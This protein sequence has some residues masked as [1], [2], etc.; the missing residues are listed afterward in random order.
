MYLKR[1]EINGFKSFANKTEIILDS[2]ITGVVGPNG[3]GKSNISDAIRWVLGEQSSK[4]LRGSKMEDVIFNGTATRSRK[5]YA[6]VSLVFDNS[7]GK[8][9][10]DYSEI[11]I[12]RKMYRSGESEYYIN[13]EQVRLR[14]IVDLMRDTGIGKE[15]YSI[16]GQGKIDEILENRP[17]ARRRVIEEAA[18]I[19]KFRARKEEAEHKLEKTQDNISRISDI[20]S[21]LDSQLGPLME[22]SEKA[23]EYRRLFERQRIV[24]ANLFLLN[25]DRF[26][27][28]LEK[29][30][31]ELC[32]IEKEITELKAV[33]GVSAEEDARMSERLNE[34]T[35]QKDELTAKLTELTKESEKQAGIVALL[36]ERKAGIIS[37]I[38]RAKADREEKIRACEKHKELLAELDTRREKAESEITITDSSIE[39]VMGSIAELESGLEDKRASFF[40]EKGRIEII[41]SDITE[42]RTEISA[43]S[44][45]LE[46]A[47]KQQRD[48]LAR[49]DELQKD[50]ALRNMQVIEEKRMLNRAKDEISNT[51]AELNEKRFT[52][53]KLKTERSSLEEQYEASKNTLARANSEKQLLLDMKAEYDGYSESVKNLMRSAKSDLR[54]KKLIRG[55]FAELIRVPEKYETAIEVVLG[56][57]LQNVVVETEQDAKEIIDFLH[58]RKLGRVTFMPLD[59]LKVNRL[60]KEERSAITDRGFLAVASEVLEF[61]ESIRPAVEFALARTVLVEDMDAAIRVMRKGDYAFRAVTLKGDFIRPGGVM[62]G[63]SAG[64]Q[65]FGLLSREHRINDAEERIRKALA[66]SQKKE[67][68]LKA[69]DDEITK[70]ENIMQLL[71]DDLSKL[72]ISAAE[73]RERITAQTEAIDA[74]ADTEMALNSEYSAIDARIADLIRRKDEFERTQKELNVKADEAR[75][76]EEDFQRSEGDRLKRKE[77]LTD[78]LNRMRIRGAELKKEIEAITENELRIKNEMALAQFAADKAEDTA[79]ELKE[80]TSDIDREKRSTLL[81]KDGIDSNISEVK[82]LCDK[83]E[84]ERSE[85]NE[86]VQIMRRTSS[87]AQQRQ[88]ELFERKFKLDSQIEKTTILKENSQQKLWDDYE[89]TYASAAELKTDLSFTAASQESGELK[90][91]IRELGPIN[92]NAIEDCERVSARVKDMSEQKADMENAKADLETVINS[93]LSAM[94]DTFEERFELLNSHFKRIF[95]DLFGGGR[96]E[97]VMGEGDILEAGIDVTAEPPGK[98]LQQLSL[99]SGGERALTA[100]ALLFAMISINPS[101]VCLFDEIDA[102]LDEAN[103][104]LFSEYLRKIEKTQFVIITHRKP[105][106]ALC[107][108]LYGVAMQEKGVST[109]VSVNLK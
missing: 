13:H 85:L 2:K 16:V 56:N 4:N 98:K 37:E 93:L 8:I 49:I 21:E 75:K 30:N 62:T 46:E 97:L 31:E 19:M 12:T 44:A 90:A 53:N 47:E 76:L 42:G 39:E 32:A 69:A 27:N 25:A 77:E 78:E 24:D 67:Q 106:M 29:M 52:I 58:E 23:K 71:M 26:A 79:N 48:L 82:A 84:A 104:R 11:I 108:S 74:A 15:G 41:L 18:G 45:K 61:D 3:S 50:T 51:A 99:L 107:D 80:K 57:S 68:L 103:A 34:L 87:E 55:T 101:P 38:E 72:E 109:L 70:L 86:R 102:P 17:A 40:K 10:I 33:T 92:P 59:A 94:R 89:L 9:H 20:L 65:R 63:G 105:T 6:E 35:A 95:T 96:A 100:I 7:D 14:D 64:K 66:E 28:R 5:A 91:K 88:T 22:Q 36:D 60:T 54:I 43:I 81:I 73:K 83:K 1:V